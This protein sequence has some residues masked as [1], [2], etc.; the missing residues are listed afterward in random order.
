MRL[1]G[2]ADLFAIDRGEKR[3]ASPKGAELT[4]VG[5]EFYPECVEQVVRYASK[6]TGVPHHGHGKRNCHQ[7]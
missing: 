7:R 5:W 3:F 6:E 2:S 4:Q 1:S